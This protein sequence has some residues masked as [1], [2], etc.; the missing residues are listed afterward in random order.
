MRTAGKIINLIIILSLA[1]LN[2]CSVIEKSSQH[3]FDNGYYMF[4]SSNPLAGKVYVNVEDQKL[5]LYPESEKVLEDLPLTIILSNADTLPNPLEFTKKSLDIDLTTVL[6]KYRP[7]VFNLPVQMNTDFN[8]ALY[9]GWRHD[10]Y[11][12]R[13]NV[14]D[15]KKSN[16][17]IVSRGY[18]F[19]LFAGP[20]TTAIN[21]FSTRNMVENEYNGMILQY[22]VAGFLESNVASFGIAAGFD[23]LLSPDR[24]F[25]IYNNK[26][27]FG[28]IIGI[29]L[30]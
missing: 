16:H 7:S 9:A 4:K 5:E 14:D 19:G 23:Y 26:P 1:L 28:L 20:G 18:D 2:S 11:L 30:N 25:W 24:G 3:G 22:G 8:I 15:L 10:K 17:D 29:A 6:L 13:N 27:W 21:P 12:I